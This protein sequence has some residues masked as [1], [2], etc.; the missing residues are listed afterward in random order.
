MVEQAVTRDAA[1]VAGSTPAV[2]LVY[3][4]PKDFEKRNLQ[5]VSFI[6]ERG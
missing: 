4:V 6:A 5:D 3:V 2:P 1:T